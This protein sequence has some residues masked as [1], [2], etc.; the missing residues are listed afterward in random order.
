MKRRTFI[1]AACVPAFATRANANLYPSRPIKLVVPT[2]AGG[3]ADFIARSAGEVMARSLGQPFVLDN[4]PGGASTLAA[5]IVAHANADG[6]TLLMGTEFNMATAA[7]LRKDIAYDPRKDLLPIGV[8]AK[9][10]LGLIVNAKLPVRSVRELVNYLR[11]RPGAVNYASAGAGTAYHLAAEMFKAQNDVQIVHVPYAGGAPMAT[12]LIRRDTEV[13]FAALN[14]YLPFIRSG[15]LRVLAIANERRIPL[16]PDVPTF[17]E[18]GFPAFDASMHLGLASPSGVAPDIIHRL[19]AALAKVWADETYRTRMATYG[20]ETPA[21]H[22]PT[23]YAE[24]LAAE[25]R[26]WQGLIAKN[27]IRME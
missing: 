14:T 24:R 25:A 3:I 10:P 13:A 6:Y 2:S 17:A 26:R 9:F 27:K 18:A 5:N 19:H 4:R 12:S 16:L 8:L 7:L 22:T 11:A 23:E 21:P 15:E 20:I 1:A